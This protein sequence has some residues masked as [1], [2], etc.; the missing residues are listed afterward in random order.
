MDTE[1]RVTPTANTI[2][3][4]GRSISCE[5]RGPTQDTVGI[6]VLGEKERRER[7]WQN[8]STHASGLGEAEVSVGRG[9]SPGRVEL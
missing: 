2:V 3:G 4:A 7:R 6:N 8:D 9:K 1:A 5:W